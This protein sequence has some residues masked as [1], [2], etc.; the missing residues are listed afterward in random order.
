LGFEKYTPRTAA[1]L[2]ELRTWIATIGQDYVETGSVPAD[3][4]DI[5]DRSLPASFDELTRGISHLCKPP[6]RAEAL[7]VVAE[8]RDSYDRKEFERAELELLKFE[9]LILDR[10]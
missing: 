8:A 9:D 5:S 6:L 7:Q 1:E 4:R 10:M 3:L 2:L